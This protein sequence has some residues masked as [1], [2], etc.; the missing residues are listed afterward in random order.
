MPEELGLLDRFTLV[1]L[2][3]TG[4]EEAGGLRS[5]KGYDWGIMN[6][7][8]EKGLISDPVGKAKSVFLTEAGRR[9]AKALLA[10]FV[11]PS[12]GSRTSNDA[13]CECGCGEP[14]PGGG[15][16]PGHDQKLR[17][18][19]ES[20]VG[21]LRALQGLVDALESYANG[22]ATAEELTREVRAVFG[23]GRSRP[24]RG[25]S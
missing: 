25:R 22:H 20:R 8:H 11:G 1:L 9:E 10:S 15:F 21:G 24:A 5:W 2:H 19:L 3:E 17:A 23:E 7:L 13:L 6:R 18:L 4:F 14:R 12:A 16:L